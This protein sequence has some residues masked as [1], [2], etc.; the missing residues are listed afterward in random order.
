MELTLGVFPG[1]IAG[2]YAEWLPLISLVQHTSTN[3]GLFQML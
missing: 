1:K 3:T 2:N